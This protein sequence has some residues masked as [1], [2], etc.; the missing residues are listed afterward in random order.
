MRARTSGMLGRRRSR[1]GRRAPPAICSSTLRRRGVGDMQDQ[2]RARDLLEGRAERLDQVVG[3]LADEPDRVGHRRLASAGQRE[4]AGGRIERGEQLVGHHDVRAGQRVQ[5]RRLAGVRVAGDRD[6]RNARTAPAAERFT[7][8]RPARSLMSRRSFVMRRRMC[9]R[10]TSSFVSPG[11]P[12][13]DA[14]AQP[15]HGLAPA[16]EAGQQVVQLGELDLGLALAAA[17]RAG[18]RCRGS[19]RSG[20]PPSRP[21][22]PPRCA[23]AR[24]RAPRPGSPARRREAWTSWWTR[25]RVPLPTNVA[26]SGSGAR[27]DHLGDGLGAGAVGEGRELLQV[28]GVADRRPGPPA[29]GRPGATSRRAATRARS[30]AA[31]A[32]RSLG[33]RE[34]APRMRSIASARRSSGTVS[35]TRK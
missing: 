30:D 20:R 31:A 2:V 1:P 12:R 25:S 4:P 21:A 9:W 13:A 19:G 28:T 27:L 16:A 3:Q 33:Q 34:S 11:P 10:S 8:A 32:S 24:A 22:A 15:G 18:R 26:G 17:A 23:A 6:L 35:E 5:Q 7:A 29:R 14:A